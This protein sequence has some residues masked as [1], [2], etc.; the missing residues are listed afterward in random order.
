MES[1]ELNNEDFRSWISSYGDLPIE[2][3]QHIF[4]FLSFSDIQVAGRTCQRWREAT[5]N[6]A[7]SK[8]ALIR[9][10]KLCL[11]DRS[12]PAQDF[13]VS[14]R[15]FRHYYFEEVNFGPIQ[16]IMSHIGNSA[17]EIVFDNVDVGDKQFCAIMSHMVKIRSL[18]ITRCSTL[19]MSGSFLDNN[20]DR[21]S[22][23]SSFGRIQHLSLKDN[24]Y[25]SD[26]I[27]LRITEI[28]DNINTLDLS[29]CQIAYHN[30]IQ[31]RF[32]PNDDDYAPSESILTFKIIIRILLMHRQTL[33]SLNI[34]DTLIGAPSLVALNDVGFEGLQ[35]QNLGLANCRQLNTLSLQTFLK[36]Q[37]KLLTLDVSDT[38]CVNDSCIDII[39]K[40]LP[41]L[42]ELNISSCINVTNNGA[43]RLGELK[44]LKTLNVSRCD[45]IQSEGLIQG[46]ASAKNETILNL[47]MAHLQVCEEAIM[48]IAKNLPELLVLNL[49]HC[50]NG[51]TDESVQCIIQNLRWLR[52]LSLENCFRITDVALTG[53]NIL[54]LP[55]NSQTSINNLQQHPLSS[56]SNRNGFNESNQS[57]KISLRSKAEEEIVRDA[58]RKKAMIAAY[59]MNLIGECD[60]E[61][62]SIKQLQGLRS[63][64]LGGCNKISDVSL[65]Y[66]LKFVELQNLSL[67]NCQQISLIGIEQLVQDCPSIETLD[68]SDCESINDK[69]IQSITI[70]LT[71]LRALHINGCSQLTDHTLDA[72]LVNCKNMQ[73]LS[74]HRCRRIYTDI[75]ERLSE[76]STLRNLKLDNTPNLDNAFLL[77]LKKHLDY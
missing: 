49:A 55:P 68:L 69:A 75:E 40:Y 57:I 43:S 5:F 6:C 13:I 48:V 2:V 58:I 19:F 35:L 14:E 26:A 66:G 31:R 36:N 67:S 18:T 30:A 15:P 63:L 77:R 44:K 64:N 37:R 24:Q 73:T 41:L 28:M 50:V 8:K 1:Y 25:L 11:S 32:Y 29:G 33:H 72:I 45:G 10:S 74:V 59:E 34:S 7:L 47:Q 51:V 54:Q 16:N 27:L 61:G 9:F 65:K 20:D 12:P 4:S 71:R 38:I 21:L 23:S 22:L 39:V 62:Y 60:V 76:M 17:E 53:I 42:Q 3:I 70:H 56:L 52:D 46:V